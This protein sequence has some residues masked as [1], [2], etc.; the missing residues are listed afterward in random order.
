VVERPVAARSGL[1][2]AYYA[3]GLEDE[4][5]L[6]GAGP[7]EFE[8]TKE[9]LAGVVAPG[10]LVADIGGGTGRYAEWLVELGCSVE[11]VDAMPLHIEHARARAGGRFGV[12]LGDARE[13]PFGDEEFDAVL[14]LGPLY[15]LQE[16]RDRVAALREAHRV[17][18]AGGVVVAAAISRLAP[19]LGSMKS[20]S[21]LE[22][23]VLAN[24]VDETGKGR[25]VPAER[26]SG[27]FPDSWFHLPEE[28]R[29]ELSEAG[30]DVRTLVGV[31]GPA[32][33][34]PDFVELWADPAARGRILETARRFGEDPHAAVLSPHLLAVARRL[35]A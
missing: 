32:W 33:L 31:E 15:H 34:S 8:R 2:D 23:R 27:L 18:R 13:L 9:L 20:G 10:M 28:L 19:L 14:L 22:P 12:R 4:R 26:R 16:R 35:P 30:L 17:C 11:L 3:Q 1:V 29:A 25:R 7:L 24:I 6:V 21:F 5:L